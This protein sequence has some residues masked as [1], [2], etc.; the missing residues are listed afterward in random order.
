MD[1]TLTGLGRP[2]VCIDVYCDGMGCHVWCL[3]HGIPVSQHIG[4]MNTTATSRHCQDMTS[5]VKVVLNPNKQIKFR[6]LKK[7]TKTHIYDSF[8]FNTKYIQ[9]INN[10]ITL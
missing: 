2:C 5:D 9:I 3:K 10:N 7:T 6:Y 4:Q 1:N 8:R